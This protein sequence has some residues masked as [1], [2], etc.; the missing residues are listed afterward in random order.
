MTSRS[1]L[2]DDPEWLV[3]LVRGADFVVGKRISDRDGRDASVELRGPV[4]RRLRDALG[5][6][7]QIHQ[8]SQT[9]SPLGDIS[10]RGTSLILR[11]DSLRFFI[12]GFRPATQVERSKGQIFVLGLGVGPSGEAEYRFVAEPHARDVFKLSRAEAELQ[13][14]RSQPTALSTASPASS[15][16]EMGEPS[17]EDYSQVVSRLRDLGRDVLVQLVDPEIIRITGWSTEESAA[18]ADTDTLA[19]LVV[20]QHNKDLLA[21][22]YVR[23][24]FFRKWHPDRQAQVLDE[25]G[26]APGAPSSRA[27]VLAEITWRKGGTWA[28]R[29]CRELQISE[30]FAG[31]A[32]E[33]KEASQE[34]IAPFV[35]LRP[36]ED[37]QISVYDQVLEVLLAGANRGIVKLPTGTGKT[38]TAVEAALAAHCRGE[39]LGPILWL[40]HSEELCEQAVI[41]FTEVWTDLGGRPS[42][43]PKPTSALRISRRWGGYAGDFDCDVMVASV[44][45]LDEAIKNESIK[46]LNTEIEPGLIIVDEAHRAV[47]PSFRRV[48]RQFRVDSRRLHREGMSPPVIGLTATPLRTV[49]REMTVLASLFLGKVIQPTNIAAEQLEEVLQQ[50]GVLSRPQ[51]EYLGDTRDR[52]VIDIDISRGATR[53]I[54]RLG[55][56]PIAPALGVLAA[57]TARNHMIVDRLVELGAQQSTLL[58]ACSVAHASALCL[59]LEARGV[60][61]SVISAQTHRSDRRSIIGAFRRGEINVICNFNVLTT[62]FDAPRIDTVMI[63]RPT[64]SPILY[65]QMIGRGLRGPRFGGTATCRIIDIAENL[66]FGGKVL[67]LVDFV[68]LPTSIEEGDEGGLESR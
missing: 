16:R 57:N 4:F 26:R 67:D 8:R 22:R 15:S 13:W 38:R 63:T 55:D 28:K 62:G 68:K 47:S 59:M 65:R 39:I 44:Q 20:Q 31:E 12:R 53:A 37:F 21:K 14:T 54:A 41:A 61:A 32:S 19:Q 5:L 7:G 48:L 58:F 11:Q 1:P 3:G 42:G 52:N 34:E 29:V 2:L 18:V 23:R 50:R 56:D 51:H 24:E 40:A 6:D 66:R 30:R 64:M 17:R 27:D 9:T 49:E 36:L 10:I 33:A 43:T 60:S 46:I 35:P 45:T 25:E